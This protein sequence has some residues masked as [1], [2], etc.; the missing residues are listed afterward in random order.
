[1]K[2]Y[3]LPSL[4]FLSATLFFS[5]QKKEKPS[6]PVIDPKEIKTVHTQKFSELVKDIRF[7]SLET[8]DNCLLS[9]DAKF[10]VGNKY[11]LAITPSII[12]LFDSD[13]K[14]I[15]KL[16]NW[17][18]GPEEYKGINQ[19]LIDEQEERFYFLESRNNSNI[20]F[21][22]LKSGDY[23]GKIPVQSMPACFAMVD[24][25]IIYCPEV[26]IEPTYYKRFGVEDNTPYEQNAVFYISGKGDITHT[27][28]ADTTLWR[29]E[30]IKRLRD[31]KLL[32]DKDNLIYCSS[33]SDTVFRLNQGKKEPFFFVYFEKPMTVL[34]TLGYN[35]EPEFNN[36]QHL[37]FSTEETL[38]DVTENS[39]GKVQ[40]PKKYY[41]L[42]KT[43]Y[44][45]CKIDRFCLDPLNWETEALSLFKNMVAPNEYM[46]YPM[47]VSKIEQIIGEK[48]EAG[49]ELTPQLKK[50][51]QQFTEQ[52]IE[53]PNPILVIGK[54]I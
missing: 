46:C 36:Q 10:W 7:V 15:R 6:L 13:G 48:K 54:I 39:L 33:F 3:L 21:I 2:H 42:N 44:T 53:D 23:T 47:T 30:D 20:R 1:M 50:L 43:D 49:E 12:Q 18:R 32:K 40:F 31:A 52:G 4:L 37:F 35:L 9:G 19:W 11:I 25:T 14:Y 29:R 22:D 41:R 8:N 5:C 24:S 27:I 38:M 17:G 26:R 28:P 16:T 34:E 45:T 51:S